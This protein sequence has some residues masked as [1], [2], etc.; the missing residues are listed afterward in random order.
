MEANLVAGEVAKPERKFPY[1]NWGPWVALLGVVVALFV[2]LVLSVPALIIGG[3]EG[4]IEALFPGGQGSASFDKGD[5]T[6]IAIDN[7]DNTFFADHEDE[8]RAFGALGQEVAGSR[9]T[10]LEASYGLAVDP[11]RGTLWISE[12]GGALL[13]FAAAG[14]GAPR[15]LRTIE[16]G[17]LSTPVPFEPERMAVDPATGALYAV[18][19]AN[20]EVLTFDAKGNLTGRIEATA[21]SAGSFDFG[22]NDND[23]AVDTARGPGRGDVF[24]L[25]GK[26]EGT[27]W[28][29]SPAGRLLWELEPA[30]VTLMIMPDR[31]PSPAPAMSSSPV[32]STAP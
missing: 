29:F 13:A 12:K 28:A 6:A 18:D 21:S 19:T 10:G 25:S 22:S 9:I 27:V 11:K 16:A 5:A 20:E 26:G 32:N 4:H 17:E 15:Q 31:S 24:V 8:V 1:A 3:Q 7:S 23:I 2:G 30:V 14:K